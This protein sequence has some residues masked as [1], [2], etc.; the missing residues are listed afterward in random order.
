MRNSTRFKTILRLLRIRHKLRKTV[1]AVNLSRQKISLF[2]L[3][4]VL[5]AAFMW[6]ITTHG[7]LAA[8]KVTTE[9]IQPGKL[10][11]EVFGIGIVEARHSY[12]I[13]P[14]MTARISKIHVDQGD[15]VQSGQIV[16]EIDPIDLNEKL[17]GSRLMSERAANIIKVEEA[18]LMEAR[19]RNETSAST[20]ARYADL[21][22]RGFIS[23]EMLDGKLHEKVAAAATLDAAA[24]GLSAARRDHEKSRAEALGMAKL[25]NQTHLSSPANGVVI[26]RLAENGAILLPGQTALQIVDPTDYWI[27]ARVDQ[28]LAGS[29]QVGQQTHIV[30][31]SR[32]QTPITGTISRIDLVSDNITEER[33]V[34]IAF[35]PTDTPATLGE[36]A[37]VTIKLP[38]IE[39]THS[40]AAAAV[41]R[42]N[43]QTGVWLL[44]NGRGRFQPVRTG[45]TTLD[46]RTEVINGLSN[47][48][49]VIVYSQQAM[50]DGLKV[51]VVP[52]LVENPQ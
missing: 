37:E 51:K 27:K 42:I 25:R 35:V 4:A 6:L 31:R 21:H 40:I 26:A 11:P 19:S 38:V 15:R 13:S 29:L 1:R 17:A 30:L 34:N 33:I 22:R 32:P 28:K 52:E 36:Q 23:Q 49:E 8:V 39:Q 47:H 5:F 20:Y 44:R 50:Q 9:K 43:Q 18:Q 46:G 24:A 48:D 10:E 16:A 7:P 41:K 12:P 3:F 2:A 14:L 45:I